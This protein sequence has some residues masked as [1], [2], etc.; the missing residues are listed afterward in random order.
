MAP[1]CQKRARAV[2]CAACA[3][4]APRWKSATTIGS[5]SASERRAR[6]H[7]DEQREAHAVRPRLRELGRSPLRGQRRERRERRGRQRHHEDALREVA[8]AHRP[9]EVALR[10]GAEARRGSAARARGRRNRR[11][12][13]ASSGPRRRRT[14]RTSGSSASDG[15]RRIADGAERRPLR[16]HLQD[17]PPTSAPSASARTRVAPAATERTRQAEGRGEQRHV[18][19]AR[20]ERGDG[21]AS[22]GVERGHAR[23]PRCP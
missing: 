17:A 21:E 6:R 5:P 19:Q 12:C 3:S 20:R 18:E 23:G 14:F 7:G 9:R 2:S 10:A 22:L 15:A 16:D 4:N 8:E 11:P 13:R 1:P